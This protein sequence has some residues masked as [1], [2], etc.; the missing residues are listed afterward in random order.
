MMSN[1]CRVN[2]KQ[3]FNILSSLWPKPI[4][5]LC[6]QSLPK[7]AR[8]C[9][10][11]AKDLPWMQDKLVIPGLDNLCVALDYASPIDQ[12]ILGGKFSN[13]LTNL[14]LLAELFLRY[15]SKQ[16]MDLPEVLIPI[17]LHAGRLR[18]RGYNQALEIAKIMGKTLKV[19]VDFSCVKRVKATK[20]Q[21]SLPARLRSKNIKAAFELTRAVHYTRVALVDDVLTTGNTAR[22]LSQVLKNA[23]V[24]KVDVYCIAR[25]VLD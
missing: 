21:A 14:S 24:E 22:E 9:E 13:Q 16:S 3:V 23:G 8:I 6:Q 11:C 5:L 10:E 12:L 19:P 18:E 17:P 1:L 20:A 25:T 15:W 4:C 2:Y 7:F